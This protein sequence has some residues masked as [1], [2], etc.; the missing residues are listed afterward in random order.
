MKKLLLVFVAILLATNVYAL[1]ET[2][3]HGPQ[4]ITSCYVT[5]MSDLVS[6]DVVILQTTSPTYYG[7]EVTS[8]T[9]AG[10][11]IYGVVVGDPTLEKCRD[12]GWINVQTYGYCSIVMV[13]T[14]NE[15]AVAALDSLRTST[16][17]KVATP[18]SDVGV[19][20]NTIALEA[21]TLPST[22]AGTPVKAFLKW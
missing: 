6:G 21:F 9:T 12:G 7:A 1:V 14:Y 8:T 4:N 2:D 15:T 18:S 22:T 5:D 20:G 16:T 17:S 13:N 19:S 10:Q 11:E 3:Q